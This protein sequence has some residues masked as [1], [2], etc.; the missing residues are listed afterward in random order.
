MVFVLAVEKWTALHPQQGPGGCMGVRP[1]VL[2]VF[3]GLGEG[4]LTMSFME[5][6]GGV[7]R[8]YEVLAP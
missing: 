1:T 8:E 5:S 2:H 4:I 7:L 6:G 3:C